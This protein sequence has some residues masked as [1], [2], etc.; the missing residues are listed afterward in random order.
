MVNEASA[1]LNI[2]SEQARRRRM[3]RL[4]PQPALIDQFKAEFIKMPEFRD[5]VERKYFTKKEPAT[6]EAINTVID[7]FFSDDSKKGISTENFFP[8]IHFQKDAFTFDVIYSSQ[9]GQLTLLRKGNESFQVINLSK[10][11]DKDRAAY[12]D[13]ANSITLGKK[14]LQEAQT[15]L[16]SLRAQN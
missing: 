11:A 6:P 9:A 5:A 10:E 13:N 2:M 4:K 3:E 1:I 14:A 15:F 16:I 12:S 8:G 7:S